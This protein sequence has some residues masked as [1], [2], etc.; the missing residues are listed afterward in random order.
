MARRGSHALCAG[1]LLLGAW[2]CS[3]GFVG[4]RARVAQQDVQT[5]LAAL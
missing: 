4:G 3:P 1:L 2:V 5:S